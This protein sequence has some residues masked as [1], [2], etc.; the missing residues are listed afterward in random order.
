[1]KLD[2]LDKVMPHM[3]PGLAQTLAQHDAAIEHLGSQMRTLQGEVHQGFAGISGT[4]AGLSSKFDK[5]DAQPKLN[6]HQ[7][8]QTALGISVLFSMVVGGI[9]WVTTSQFAGMVAEQKAVNE[10]LTRTTAK[11]SDEIKDLAGRADWNP[12]VQPLKR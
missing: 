10:H 11:N 7:A 9:I 6:V 4:L 1:M 5:L 2:P 8:V 12:V 3:T